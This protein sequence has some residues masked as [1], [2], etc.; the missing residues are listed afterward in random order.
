MDFTN[1]KSFFGKKQ[2]DWG[3]WNVIYRARLITN[4]GNTPHENVSCISYIP[5]HN[6]HKIEK[7]GR[8]NKPNESMFYGSLGLETAC[9]E[10]VTKGNVF[11][12]RKSVML[13]VGVWKF[14]TPLTIVQMPYSE[15]YI[16]MFYEK[17]RY[18][19]KKIDLGHIAEVNKKQR[20]RLEDDMSYE[21][22]E[23]FAD[24]FAK[25][26]TTNDYEYMLS[27]YYADRIFNRLSGF[28]VEGEIDGIMYPSI[29]LSYEE[30]NMVLKPEVVDSKLKFIYAYQIRM[31]DLKDIGLGAQW[32][33]IKRNVKAD[34]AGRLLW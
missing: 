12:D 6:L 1:E 17:V 23:F 18:K 24:E 32:N 16:K 15:K 25:W 26:N 10:A 2:M 4:K 8:V 20:E 5:K 13:S 28:E 19:S 14:E 27:N 22:L 3:G 34:E 9:A 33:A 30:T 31:D 29:A 7:F 21:V 11:K